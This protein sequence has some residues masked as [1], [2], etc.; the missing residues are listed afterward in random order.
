[1]HWRR[2][3]QST[4]YRPSTSEVVDNLEAA[5]VRLQDYAFAQSSAL[6]TETND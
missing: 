4:D 5:K 2:C 1:M 3:L 6:M